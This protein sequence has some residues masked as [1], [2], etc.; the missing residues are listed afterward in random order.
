MAFNPSVLIRVFKE[1][2]VCSYSN[3]SIFCKCNYDCR[4]FCTLKT[5]RTCINCTYDKYIKEFQK[6]LVFLLNPPEIID[7]SPYEKLI[8]EGGCFVPGFKITLET[9][10]D[11]STLY[12]DVANIVIGYVMPEIV[13]LGGCVCPKASKTKLVCHN[14]QYLFNLYGKTNKLFC[15]CCLKNMCKPIFTKKANEFHNNGFML[16]DHFIEYSVINLT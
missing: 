11:F 9:I 12:P 15:I 3:E 2:P 13:C 1:Q 10:M 14:T 5:Y 6:S 16:L 4:Y 8:G 7:W